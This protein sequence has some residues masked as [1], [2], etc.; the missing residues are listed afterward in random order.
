MEAEANHFISNEEYFA[1]GQDKIRS[2]EIKGKIQFDG[3]YVI[4]LIGGI[5]LIGL[6]LLELTIFSI[7]CFFIGGM[8]ISIV[9]LFMFERND[10]VRYCWDKRSR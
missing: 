5:F 1:T 2:K 4:P 10:L 6:G 8:F 7:V 9:C 3:I